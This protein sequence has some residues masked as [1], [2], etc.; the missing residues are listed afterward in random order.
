MVQGNKEKRTRGTG[1]ARI[2]I[3]QIAEEA[4]V[5]MTTVS[6]VLNKKTHRVSEEKIQLIEEIIE[7]HHYIP[8]M[9]ARSLV[10]SS[11]KLIGL[12]YYSKEDDFIFSDPFTSELLAGIEK[13]SK[14]NGYFVLVHNVT[15]I[16]DILTLQK[17]WN[18]DG[19]IVVGVSTESF[20]EIDNIIK[21]PVVYI[22]TYLFEHDQKI[23]EKKRQ[24][25]FVNTNDYQASET[26]VEFLIEC[27]HKKIGF[28]SF[29]FEPSI[30]SVIQQR[31]LAY[32]E[33]LEKHHIPYREEFIFDEHEFD[34]IQNALN[35]M[36]A[37][38]VTS[39]HLA[40]KFVK[41]LKNRNSYSVET[42]S[43]IGFDDVSFSE[44]MDPGL[45][46]IRLEPSEK[47]RIAFKELRKL[48][49]GELTKSQQIK[50]D[51]KLIVRQSVITI[52]Q[53]F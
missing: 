31:H 52:S 41:Y 21:K 48:I 19:F 36:T 14:R 30:P 5:S 24:C 25:S 43:I 11:S 6:N 35:Q 53:K 9:N 34:K 33:G 45:T 38:L 23:M 2:T 12:L 8:N 32:K 18:F 1:M 3:K 44:L 20:I 22:D 27:S 46:T 51:G 16:N 29:D 10:N 4:G 40:A 47:G 15:S 7:K 37:L 28:L 39:D 49:L 50:M 42:L 13:E 26:A 17:N